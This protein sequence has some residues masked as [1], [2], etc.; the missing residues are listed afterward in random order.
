MKKGFSPKV[1]DDFVTSQTTSRWHHNLVTLS[2]SL[3]SREYVKKNPAG[4]PWPTTKQ[5]LLQV[6]ELNLDNCRSTGG[7]DGLTDEFS[8]LKKLSMVNIGLKTLKGFPALPNLQKLELSDNQI[9][10]TLECLKGCPAIT[11][12]NLSGNKIETVDVLG[13]L[14]ELPHLTSLDLFNCEVTRTSRYR[15][16]VFDLLPS[17]K[18]LDSFD[19]IDREAVDS[20]NYQAS[21]DDEE[22]GQLTD[23][24]KNMANHYQKDDEDND[25]SDLPTAD[26]ND[27]IDSDADGTESSEDDKEEYG[28]AYLGGDDIPDED[29]DEDYVEEEEEEDE[30]ILEDEKDDVPHGIKR[31]LND[32]SDEG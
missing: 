9:S 22:S 8:F 17:L 31:K 18:Y 27:E 7:L 28:L 11:H 23:S 14:V 10:G 20:E 25:D 32:D 15:E 16:C 3:G 5:E 29:D 1:D 12:L 4:K 30:E 26:S 24:K 2:K 13:P 6:T 21:G 19:Y